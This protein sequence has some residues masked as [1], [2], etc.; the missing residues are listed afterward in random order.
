MI[1]TQEQIVEIKERLALLGIKDT[2]IRM[3][4]SDELLD[5]TGNESFVIVKDGENV[6]ISLQELF[7]RVAVIQDSQD[8][9]IFNVSNYV[10]LNDPEHYPDGRLSLEDA[11]DNTPITLQREGQIITFEN[12][13]GKWKR[14]QMTAKQDASW[15]TYNFEEL[16]APVL[17]GEIEQKTNLSEFNNDVPYL[18]ANTLTEQI[19]RVMSKYVTL[20]QLTTIVKQI[21]ND[22]ADKLY[23]WEYRANDT[24]LRIFP[25]KVTNEGIIDVDCDDEWVE[26]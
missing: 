9:D 12:T 18:T 26:H 3:L 23:N 22:D 19:A 21:E 24:E 1:F 7:D 10:T 2:Q 15:S 14:Y 6:R 11:V 4:T 5:L 20:E 25:R 17:D 16:G 13:E 8:K